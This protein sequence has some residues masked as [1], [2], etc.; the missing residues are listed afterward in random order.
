MYYMCK[1]QKF[2]YIYFFKFYLY[3]H[4]ANRKKCYDLRFN[5]RCADV[6]IDI[7]LVL[8]KLSMI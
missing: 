7:L 1:L 2:H 5:E 6:A 4:L 3:I 8:S